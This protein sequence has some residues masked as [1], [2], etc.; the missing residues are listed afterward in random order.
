ML[1]PSDQYLL[2][3]SIK[4]RGM[5]KEYRRR[6]E[7]VRFTMKMFLVVSKTLKYANRF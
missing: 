6:S 7:M 4:V 1:G 3:R 2:V 5:V